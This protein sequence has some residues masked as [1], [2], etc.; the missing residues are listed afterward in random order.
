MT[1]PQRQQRNADR[2]LELFP[3]FHQRIA[4]VIA[5]LEAINV[6]PRIQDAYRSPA[7]Q[8]K[9]FNSGHSKLKFGF[10]NVTGANGQKESL[11]VDMLDDDS[12]LKTSTAYVLKLAW[13][14]EKNGLMTGIRWGVPVRLIVAIDK[15]ITEKDWNA[16]VKIGW[17][18][19]HIQ[20]VGITAADAKAGK[21]PL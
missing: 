19:T 4:K 15:A 20:P 5:D 9:A 18:P 6:R 10:H 14:A 1:E 17:D 7:D 11:A 12:P 8:L 21:R 2:L 3:T 16:P 13:A